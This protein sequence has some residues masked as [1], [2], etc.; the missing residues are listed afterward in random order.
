MKKKI[1]FTGILALALVFGL[2]LV[3]GMTLVACDNLAGDSPNDN[4]NNN[5]NNNDNNDNNNSNL[6]A[7]IDPALAGTS[8]KDNA[9][10]SVLTLSFTSEKVTW[11]GSGG[12]ALDSAMNSYSAYSPVWF[13]KDGY[14]SLKYNVPGTGEQTYQ[15]YGYELSGANLLLKSGG[16][17]FVTMVRA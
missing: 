7:Y 12:S 4:N 8:W 16:I 10:G 2:A 15:I 9:T 1:L 6:T 17:T 5:N 3:M 14:I 11:G 13:V